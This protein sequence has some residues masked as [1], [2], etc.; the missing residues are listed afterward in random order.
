VP[1]ERPPA[2]HADKSTVPLGFLL[3]SAGQQVGSGFRDALAPHAVTPRQFAVL[4]SL[5]RDGSQNQQQLSDRLRI[6]P[7]RVVA[8]VDQLED[9]G[10]LERRSIPQDRRTR[11]VTL[12]P[13]GEHLIT[14]LW[15]VAAAYQQHLLGDLTAAEQTVLRDLLHRITGHL[16]EGSADDPLRAW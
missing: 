7:S 2:D 9:R 15:G 11:S 6:P 14:R 12:T 13:D 8:L 3:A 5:S 10:W 16:S 4:W 1:T